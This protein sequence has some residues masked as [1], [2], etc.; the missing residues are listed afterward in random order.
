MQKGTKAP[1]ALL[2]SELKN[3]FYIFPK[4]LC[5]FRVMLNNDNLET[6]DISLYVYIPIIEVD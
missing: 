4:W 6:N 2:Q 1:E 3:T 5:G